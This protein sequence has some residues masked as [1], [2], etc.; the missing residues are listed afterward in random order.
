M[1]TQTI[2]EATCLRNVMGW[3]IENER[4]THIYIWTLLPS[5]LCSFPLLPSPSRSFPLLPTSS[6]SFALLPI[7]SHFFPLLPTSSHSFLLLPAPPCSFP[8]SPN[9][10]LSVFE[11]TAENVN[12]Q[13]IQFH[14]VS[15][16][17]YTASYSV[18][19]SYWEGI[20]GQNDSQRWGGG[21]GGGG[22]GG[23]GPSW[24]KMWEIRKF[25]IKCHCSVDIYHHIY[26]LKA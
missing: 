20:F 14:C 17:A 13:M 7:P 15:N 9:P 10:D 16:K 5:P 11:Q 22:V 2:R 26:S 6:H 19:L 8:L 12:N 4:G 24:R 25:T 21:W 3:E 18:L 23:K 1:P